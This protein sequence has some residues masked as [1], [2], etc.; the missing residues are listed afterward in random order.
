MNGLK[1]GGVV[2]DMTTSNPSLGTNTAPLGQH[3]ADALLS[4]WR[5]FSERSSLF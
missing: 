2:V 1:S 3:V 5:S 4:T